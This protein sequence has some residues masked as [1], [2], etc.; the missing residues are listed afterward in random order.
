ME[1]QS[2]VSAAQP[3]DVTDEREQ[4][5]S[6]IAELEAQVRTLRADAGHPTS[7]SGTIA[8]ALVPVLAVMTALLTW[9][10]FLTLRR[11]W[12]WWWE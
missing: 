7:V 12:R 3:T 10:A 5:R 11:W 2:G 8:K 4:L 9:P 1:R 6:R